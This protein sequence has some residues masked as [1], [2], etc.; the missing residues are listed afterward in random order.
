MPHVHQK[1]IVKARHKNPRLFNESLHPS[2]RYGES[3]LCT[4]L[5]L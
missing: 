1:E 4:R 5:S 3:R 2:Q